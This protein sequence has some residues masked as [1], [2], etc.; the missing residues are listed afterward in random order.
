MQQ[1]LGYDAL[2][3]GVSYLPLAIVIIVSAG[4]ASQLVTKIGFKPILV[5]GMVLIAIAL[6][7]F[8]QVPVDGS[9]LTH[10]LG[11]MIISA[12]GLGFAFV[13]VTIGAVSGVSQDDSGLASGLINTTQQLGGALGLSV[14]VAVASGVITNDRD[15]VDLTEGFQAAFLTG[16]GIAVLGIIAA[17]TL[18]RSA[19]SRA[20]VGA[21]PAALPLA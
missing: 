12:I 8:A 18:I 21:D 5:T 4:I 11:P 13:P 17:V 20:L 6:V 3:A 14:L 10:L 2:K 15:P 7:W 16:A 1:V 9:Y 19:D